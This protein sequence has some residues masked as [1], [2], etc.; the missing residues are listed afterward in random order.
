MMQTQFLLCA[1]P[2]EF[3]NNEVSH[4]EPL[5]IMQ[6]LIQD[7]LAIERRLPK[8]VNLEN[9]RSRYT[10]CCQQIENIAYQFAAL[11]KN[12]DEFK[13]ILQDGRFPAFTIDETYLHFLFLIETNSAKAQLASEIRFGSSFFPPDGVSDHATKFRE[14]AQAEGWLEKTAVKLRDKFFT[15]A[16]AKNCGVIEIQTPLIETNHSEVMPDVLQVQPS[17]PAM[18]ID[19]SAIVTEVVEDE[20]RRKKMIRQ[21][22]S[23]IVRASESGEVV[24]FSNQPH[25]ITTEVLHQFVYEIGRSQPQK[26]RVVYADGSEGEPFRLQRP[27]IR[28]PEEIKYLQSLMPIKMA[29]IS[30]RHLELDRE[31]DMAWYRN[32]EASRSRTLSEADNFCFEYSIK[33]FLELKE[34]SELNNGV[35]LHLYH[36]GFEPAV[37]A[38]YRAFINCLHAWKNDFPGILIVPQYYRGTNSYKPGKTW[39]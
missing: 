6:E 35:H 21:L 3:W 30:M 28:T 18:W 29:L 38:F 10:L 19:S 33:Q 12:G 16:T 39:V 7:A 11:F 4:P 37:I 17:Q 26:I 32:R 14:L 13:A 24:N 15:W 34:L 1:V 36:T 23:Q 25:D 31:V 5:S 2:A 20:D 27:P 8:N 9:E 22:R